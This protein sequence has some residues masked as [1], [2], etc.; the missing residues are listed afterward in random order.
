MKSITVHI[1]LFLFLMSC[2]TVEVQQDIQDVEKKESFYANGK[3]ERIAFYR[4]SIIDSLYAHYDPDG[5][6]DTTG[7]YRDGEKD[8]KWKEVGIVGIIQKVKH[9]PTYN[10]GQVKEYIDS[11]WIIKSIHP[12]YLSSVIHEI[13]DTPDSSRKWHTDWYY[14]G[15]IN[16]QIYMGMIADTEKLWDSTGYLAEENINDHRIGHES[17]LQSFYPDGTLKEEVII[18][19]GSVWL[20][21]KEYNSEG[22]LISQKRIEMGKDSPKK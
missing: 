2:G 21:K 8:G 10:Y 3:I 13:F 12:P 1:V 16:R 4:D 5:N 11:S 19:N 7:F 18:T 15:T 6:I 20:V 22:K 14:N 17:H 9:Y